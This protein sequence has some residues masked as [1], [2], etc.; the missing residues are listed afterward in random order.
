MK[1]G[2]C[3]YSTYMP[4]VRIAGLLFTISFQSEKTVIAVYIYETKSNKLAR[5][6]TKKQGQNMNP[7]VQTNAHAQSDSTGTV[8]WFPHGTA[9]TTSSEG[10]VCSSCAKV[11][12][13][14]FSRQR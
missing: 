8:K 14:A 1:T 12:V 2:Y 3:K 11:I 6:Q 10:F 4:V 9:R 5:A 7:Y 13:N